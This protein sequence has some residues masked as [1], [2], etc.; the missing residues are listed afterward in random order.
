MSHNK[1]QHL[2]EVFQALKVITPDTASS[3]IH[4]GSSASVSTPNILPAHHARVTFTCDATSTAT[5]STPDTRH[6]HGIKLLLPHAVHLQLLCMPMLGKGLSACEEI[7]Q[8][9]L[10]SYPVHKRPIREGMISLYH[11]RQGARG[12]R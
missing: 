9:K 11:I 8:H 5:P 3:T 1:V 10:E 2:L 12:C 6:G 7:G 4:A